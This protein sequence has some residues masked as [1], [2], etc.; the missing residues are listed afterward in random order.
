MNSSTTTSAPEAPKP[1]P[2][3]VVDRGERFLLRHRH[4]SDALACGKAIGLHDDR[5]TLRTE[6]RPWPFPRR[7]N[8]S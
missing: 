7:Q 3:I 2:N 1:P 6:Y 8:A 5:R 4:Q